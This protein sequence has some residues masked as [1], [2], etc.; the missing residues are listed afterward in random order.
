M[1]KR[2]QKMRFW[3]EKNMFAAI[4]GSFL[5]VLSSVF[6]HVYAEETTVLPL[7]IADKATFMVELALTEEERARGLMFR[8]ELADD[9]GMLF[10]TEG[11]EVSSMWM[12][13]TFI[14]LDMVFIA[15]KHIVHIHE[16]AKPEDLTPISSKVPVTAVLELAGGVVKKKGI[17]VGDTVELEIEEKESA[18]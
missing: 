18:Q 14:P 12:K 11:A 6:S 4:F 8:Q 17:K 9:K 15:D 13:N 5:L 10:L 3:T 7:K 2:L 1:N 16:N